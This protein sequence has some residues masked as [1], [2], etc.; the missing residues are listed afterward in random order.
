VGAW[1]TNKIVEISD[2]KTNEM[3]EIKVNNFDSIL[4]NTAAKTHPKKQY[5]ELAKFE[6]HINLEQHPTPFGKVVVN[7][8][9]D[10]NIKKQSKPK[11]SRLEK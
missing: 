4:Q 7:K 9:S 6:S 3:P 1:P 11:T 10:I 8:S 2:L 5:M